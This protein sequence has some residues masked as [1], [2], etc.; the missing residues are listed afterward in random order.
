VLFDFSQR[1][2]AGRG[3]G[4]DAA[5][6]VFPDGGAWERWVRFV[7]RFRGAVLVLWL[8]V[9]VS[10]ILLS[11][12]LPSHL[13]NSFAVPGTPSARAE[14]ALANGF[15]E[16]PEGTFTVVFR[17]RHSSDRAVQERLRTRL[18]HAAHVL[19]GGHLATF[20]AG[21]GVVYGDV[22][23]S[24]SLQRAKAYTGTLRRAVGPDALVTG[25]PAIQHD[26]DP[27]LASDLRRGE[28]LALPLAVL[29]L[30][31]VLGFSLALA[32]PV[33]F[34]AC[35]IAGT[36]ALLYVT[37]RLVPVTSY[38]T[39]LVELIG[40][41][42]AID[43]SLLIVSRFRE[44]VAE[45]EEV[46]AAVA[47]TMAGAGRAVVFSGLAV[48]IGLALLFFVPVPFIRTL[49]L[50][51]L[52]IPLVSIAGAMTL[53]PA[54]LS[55]CGRR[56]VRRARPRRREPWAALAR[57]I[58][59]RP[60]AVLV[61]T[62]AALLAAAAPIFALHVTPGS[63][64][65][66]PRSTE[67]TRGFAVLSDAFGPGALTPTELVV[68]TGRPGAA[69]APRIHTALDTIANRLLRDHE[70]SAVAIGTDATYV[71]RDG[72]YARMLVVGRHDYGDPASRALVSRLRKLE[73]PHTTVLVGG[74][75][76][77]GADFL[78]RSYA[79]LPWLVAL[80][81]LL[82]FLVLVRAFR[83]LLLPLK[84]VA[85]NL[86]SVAAAYGLLVAVFRYGVGAGLLGVER[87]AQIEGWIPI[88]LFAVLFGLSMD[89]EV[90]L[91]SRMREE[92]DE[93]HDNVGAVAF[94]LERTGRLITA[95]AL[96]M[97]VSFGGF[98]VG[99]VPGLQQ[100]GLGLALAVLI[101]ATLVR[102][103]LVPSLMALLG[104]WNWWLPSR[105]T[106]RQ[107]VPV[108]AALAL[109]AALVIAPGGSAAP[110]KTVRLAI[111]HV[112][113]N[114]HIWRTAAR[115][116]GPTTKLT[117]TR[118]TKVVIRSDC[119]MDFDF[120]QTKGP[121]LALG[122]PRT[123]AGTSRTLTFRKTGTYRLTATNVQTPEER[124]LTVLGTPNTLT[125]TV[126]VKP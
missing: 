107:L 25:Q 103:L 78:S 98:V 106:R 10:G 2:R 23:T 1:R 122:D 16:R 86:L 83:S 53:Q 113:S 120:A 85:L 76:P 117:V 14:T 45:D 105:P 32:I 65:S 42:L 115:A 84:A 100:F 111:A 81:L 52:L 102:A 112:V 22:A 95:A 33:V 74:A 93:R 21:L 88:F 121:K 108:A 41:G 72:R 59:R 15:G 5:R 37:A 87:S 28:M 43:Y 62:A 123:Y 60:L 64:S 17:V 82:T 30:A 11:L 109:V 12:H 13:V 20:R 77:K 51:G 50:A 9:L 38:A 73:V 90:F 19:P 55:V 97:A 61:P 3:L 92:W 57:A 39:N 91:V 75:G 66:L 124:G 36:L 89:Y 67:A 126:V 69:R 125:L 63:L 44:E 40:L 48:A 110:A 114:C 54:L 7:L 101:D 27:R 49:G 79:P 35:T 70:V 80:A 8:A 46:D 118:G 24:L 99:S 6:S 56:L 119:P 29:V 96:V 71:S 26:L 18:V 34:A 94:G 31:L 116:L 47:R 104:R 68:D 4:G 58:M